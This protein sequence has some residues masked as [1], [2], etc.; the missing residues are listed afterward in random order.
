MI[1]NGNFTKG[2]IHLNPYTESESWMCGYFNGW[3][4]VE[5]FQLKLSSPTDTPAVV[6]DDDDEEEIPPSPENQR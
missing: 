5:S 3:C 2:R 4:V 6:E 1:V